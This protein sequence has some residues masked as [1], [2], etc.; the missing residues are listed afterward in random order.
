MKSRRTVISFPVFSDYAV[1]VIA[2]KSMEGTGRR[3]GTPLGHASGAVITKDDDSMR[4]WMVLGPGVDEATVAHESVHAVKAMFKAVGVQR[5]EETFAYH[6]GHLVGEVH[7]F[8][9]KTRSRR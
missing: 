4:C 9:R 1:V 6:L 7:K 3:L 5:D 2:A 8:L